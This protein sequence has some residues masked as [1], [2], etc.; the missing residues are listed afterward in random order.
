MIFYSHSIDLWCHLKHWNCFWILKFY[1]SALSGWR[2]IAIPLCASLQVDRQADIW[3]RFCRMHV[4]E[5]TGQIFFNY[6]SLELSGP[7]V[8]QCHGHL[9]YMSLLVGRCETLAL[10]VMHQFQ[11]IWIS[12]ISQYI[13]SVWKRLVNFV[14]PSLNIYWCIA[15]TFNMGLLMGCCFSELDLCCHSLYDLLCP[16]LRKNFHPS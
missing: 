8:V 11:S 6:S 14:T 1:N 3:P 2:A 7:V 13:S 15:M 10:K 12:S 9:S 16:L 5:I 4:S